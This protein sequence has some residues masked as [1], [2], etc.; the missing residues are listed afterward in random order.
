MGF[1]TAAGA[2]VDFR[3]VP[4]S[5]GTN[6]DLLI[7]EVITG[8]G[9]DIT[10]RLSAGAAISLGIAFNDGP[11]VGIGGMTLDYALRGTLGLTYDLTA[12]TSLGFYYQTPQSF[13]FDNAIRLDLGGGAFSAVQDIQM[14]LPPN[15]GIG[16]ANNSLLDGNLLLAADVLYKQWNEADLFRALY[17]DQ[18]VVQV[19]GQYSVGRWRLR[20][21]YAWAENPL[22]PDPGSSA[23]GITPPGL[24][25][26]IRYVQG[27][28]AVANPHRVSAGIGVADVLPG[29]DLDLLAGG[30]FEN[31][32]QLGSFTSASAESY[33]LG[34]GLT[35]RFGCGACAADLG[36]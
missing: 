27:L 15:L 24:Q 34:M 25:D 26:A 35:W 16:I 14:D 10:D 33:W 8:V 17:D 18:F 21:G 11:F 5:N 4:A 13:T 28:M 20:L 3:D 32:E 22:D 19:G 31:T 30:M 1:V 29:V 2:G 6:A 36:Q 7:F 23:G 9:V 12:D